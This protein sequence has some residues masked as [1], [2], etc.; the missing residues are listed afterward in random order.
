M[1]WPDETL[2]EI[3]SREDLAQYLT[4]LADK[5]RDGSLLAENA[6][7]DSFVESA[8]RWTKSMDGFFMNVMKEPVP[9]TPD[10]AIIAAIFRAALVYE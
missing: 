3:R 5:V 2:N 6:T 10:W 7:T 8:G 1:N 4:G 9:E